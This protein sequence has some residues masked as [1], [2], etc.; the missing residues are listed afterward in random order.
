MWH[1]KPGCCFLAA[2]YFVT[3][4]WILPMRMVPAG[5]NPSVISGFHIIRYLWPILF[6]PL[7]LVW[8]HSC[9]CFSGGIAEEN[10]G[11]HLLLAGVLFILVLVYPIKRL[12]KEK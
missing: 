2:N 7:Y 11:R 10:T 8:Q 12:L 1:S 6:S 4:H 9:W 5:W 3:W